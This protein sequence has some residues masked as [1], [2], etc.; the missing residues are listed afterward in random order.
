M[1]AFPRIGEDDAAAG[2]GM[3]FFQVDDA[4]REIRIFNILWSA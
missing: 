2:S 3:L 1:A 4:A